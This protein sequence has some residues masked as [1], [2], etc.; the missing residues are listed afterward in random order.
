M[1]RFATEWKRE[2]VNLVINLFGVFADLLTG[3]MLLHSTLTLQICLQKRVYRDARRDLL[4]NRGRRVL[5]EYVCALLIEK[6]SAGSQP[7]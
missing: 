3:S 6:Q 4:D 7:H 5:Y 1:G 2:K